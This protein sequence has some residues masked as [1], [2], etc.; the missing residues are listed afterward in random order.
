[1]NEV[2]YMS[3]LELQPISK[4]LTTQE[5]A[6]EQIKKSILSGNIPSKAIFTEVQLAET[7]NISR[8]PVRAALQ[9]LLN[10][11]LITL[12]PRKGVMV[13]EVT[14]SEQ[15]ELFLLRI[16]IETKVIKRVAKQITDKQV[17]ELQNIC[18]E[19]KEEIRTKDS[20]KFIELDM[21]FHQKII[22]ILKFNFIKQ[23]LKNAN[24]ILILTGLKALGQPD[25]AVNIVAEH[26]KIVMA[27]KERDVEA[28]ANYMK[29]H[30]IS[31]RESL[32]AIDSNR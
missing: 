14:E 4:E 23:V 17:E 29:E 30:L 11:G 7:L 26:E 25:R 3:R 8:T 19:Q 32:Q 9:D 6:Y 13:R 31:T 12:V 2:D 18:E 21:K 16:A 24:D 10:E 22:D 5:K 27:L 1:M 28:A 20:L 15:D